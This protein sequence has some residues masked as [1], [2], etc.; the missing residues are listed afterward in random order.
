MFHDS[1]YDKSETEA[2]PLDGE[3]QHMVRRN[4]LRV[5]NRPDY[6]EQYKNYFHAMPDF[7]RIHN[8]KTAGQASE[9]T[10]PL[11]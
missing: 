7:S 5:F 1:Q 9:V 10:A 11:F 3:H 6:Q 2:T 4:D 8:P